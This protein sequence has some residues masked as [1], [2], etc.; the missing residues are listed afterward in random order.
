MCR[1]LLTSMFLYD[2]PRGS[3]VQAV[4]QSGFAVLLQVCAAVL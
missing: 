2:A 3:C 1:V 4:L